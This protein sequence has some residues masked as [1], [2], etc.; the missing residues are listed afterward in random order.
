MLIGGEWLDSVSGKTFETY[1]PATGAPILLGL[2]RNVV[3][4]LLGPAVAIV[5]AIIHLF[6]KRILPIGCSGQH[7]LD[8]GKF[9]KIDKRRIQIAAISQARVFIGPALEHLL[10]IAVGSDEPV[11][12]EWNAALTEALLNFFLGR[13]E[14]TGASNDHLEFAIY[15]ADARQYTFACFAN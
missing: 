10:D 9:A 2:I 15:A 6:E 4:V 3:A 14:D 13:F 11:R 8:T 1:N 7:R 5:V 12:P